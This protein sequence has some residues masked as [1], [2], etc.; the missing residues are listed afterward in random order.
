MQ[1]TLLYPVLSFHLEETVFI[2]PSSEIF[3]VKIPLLLRG[4]WIFSEATRYKNIDTCMT[5]LVHDSK[6]TKLSISFIK[7]ER[8]ITE[9]N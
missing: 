2:P 5:S 8:Q 3:Y 4:V 6:L 7:Q 9:T 1:C